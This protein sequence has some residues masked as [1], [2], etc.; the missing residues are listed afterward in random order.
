MK[1]KSLPSNLVSQPGEEQKDVFTIEGESGKQKSGLFYGVSNETG[2]SK[3]TVSF[4]GWI[5]PHSLT[6]VHFIICRRT[7]AG[8]D[9]AY[10]IFTEG[11]KLVIFR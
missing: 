3:D 8:L 9:L 10:E 1:K 4:T 6:G 5:Y 2:G 7:G 11:N